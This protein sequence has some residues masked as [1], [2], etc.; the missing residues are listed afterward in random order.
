MT[1][2]IMN[3]DK[4][5]DDNSNND[6]NNTIGFRVSRIAIRIMMMMV[7]KPYAHTSEPRSNYEGRPHEG[8]LHST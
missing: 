6:T 2:L 8:A 5:N 1:V 4:N 7:S 3:N